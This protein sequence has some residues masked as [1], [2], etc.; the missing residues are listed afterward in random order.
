MEKMTTSKNHN[1]VADLVASVSDSKEF[2][3]DFNE[4]LAKRMLIKRLISLR[5]AKSVSQADIAKKLACTQSR[6]S[7]L[8]AGEDS[9]LRIGELCEYAN[10]IGLEVQIGLMPKGMR[11][12]DR[13]KAHAFAIKRLL[14]EMV[15]LA[16]GDPGIAKGIAG[17]FGE[18]FFNLLGVVKE[19]A[20][21][22]PKDQDGCPYIQIEIFDEGDEDPM[23]DLQFE[24][25]KKEK[26]NMVECST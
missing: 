21:K 7:K 22:L 8:E 12:T 17:F 9:D 18:A 11:I 26:R 2:V 5:S 1:S 19:S 6:I 3:R 20:E 24:H 13:I 4:H 23:S 16:H 25:F 10:A 15:R 14:N